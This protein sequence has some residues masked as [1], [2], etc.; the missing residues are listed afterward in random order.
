[1]SRKSASIRSLSSGAM[2]WTKDAAPNFRP[3]RNIR[4]FLNSKLLG[5]MKSLT[6]RPLGASQSQENRNC[7]GLSMW[8]MLCI[9][10]RRSAPFSG[11]ADTPRRLKLLRISVSMRSSRGFA[12]LMFSA[13]MEKVRYLVLA[14]PLF[15]LASWFCSISEYSVRTVLNS[16]ALGWMLMLSELPRPAAKLRKDS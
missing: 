8:K 16:S 9:S 7:S 14:R 12:A 13:S 2:I 15:P 5:A 1:M 4:P 11:S 6:D 3:M 10:R